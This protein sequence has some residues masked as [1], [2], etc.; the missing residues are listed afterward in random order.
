MYKYMRAGIYMIYNIE[1]G[2]VRQA[3]GLQGHS[4][5]Y[6]EYMPAGSV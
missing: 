2:N 6:N 5:I 1:E 4:V 3:R